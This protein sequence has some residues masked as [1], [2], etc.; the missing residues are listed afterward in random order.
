M[1][2]E[3]VNSIWTEI[4][5]FFEC[6]PNT[7]YPRN[8]ANKCLLNK[9]LQWQN[10]LH[11][12]ITL[13]QLSYLKTIQFSLKYKMV[14]NWRKPFDFETDLTE[15]Q[16]F[17]S[18]LSTIIFASNERRLSRQKVIIKHLRTYAFWK[19]V[20]HKFLRSSFFSLCYNCSKN[21]T[22]AIKK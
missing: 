13:K 17:K 4:I 3:T 2:N 10:S 12:R 20:Q 8:K 6:N 19:L 15:S 18:E 11:T 14:Y 1:N 21:Y 22:C 9:K 5:H 16:L 7:A